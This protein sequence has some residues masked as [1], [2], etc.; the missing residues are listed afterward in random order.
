[1]NNIKLS[2]HRQQLICQQMPTKFNFYLWLYNKKGDFNMKSPFYFLN[3]Y[4]VLFFHFFYYMPY[5]S[6]RHLYME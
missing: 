2:P 3:R 5:T 1:M 4:D 6:I